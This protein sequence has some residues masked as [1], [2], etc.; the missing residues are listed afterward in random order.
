MKLGGTEE[1]M[2]SKAAK[3]KIHSSNKQLE[4]L[5]QNLYQDI[6]S[7]T[8]QASFL[9]KI[10][11]H[12]LNSVKKLNSKKNEEEKKLQKARSEMVA[13]LQYDIEILGADLSFQHALLMERLEEAKLR[14]LTH[15]YTN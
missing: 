11:R 15:S 8:S 12:Q 6:L 3:M 13:V 2:L 14:L 9:K 10:T 7:T 1:N 5:Y 4:Q